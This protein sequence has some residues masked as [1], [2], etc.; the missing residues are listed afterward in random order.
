MKIF[1]SIL[2]LLLFSC[3]S[4]KKLQSIKEESVVEI[5]RDTIITIEQ[6]SDT[7]YVYLPTIIN[8]DSVEIKKEKSSLLIKKNTE[9]SL[10]VIC[11]ENE[12]QLKLDSVIKIKTKIFKEKIVLV[13]NKCT[14]KFHSF[15]TYFS[16]IVLCFLFLFALIKYMYD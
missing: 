15:C 7:F 12:L 14:N 8:N 3:S 6:R 4:T 1:S 5:I 13:E 16:I 11:K 2:L 9:S 10:I